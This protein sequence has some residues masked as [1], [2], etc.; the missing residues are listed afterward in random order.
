MNDGVKDYLIAQLEKEGYKH[1]REIP[2]RGLCGISIFMF[3]A[4]ILYNLD[5][6]GYSGRWCY[7]SESEALHALD[8]WDGVG[9]PPGNWIKYKGEGGER[10]R[11][12]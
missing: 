9:D 3:T 2:G 5:E 8:K 4:G 1:I 7:H 6:S 10:S 12:N 11:A